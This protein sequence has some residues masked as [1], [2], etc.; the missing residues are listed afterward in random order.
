[1][2]KSFRRRARGFTLI[3]IAI[4]LF[5]VSLLLTMMMRGD[6]LIQ[7]SRVQDT[8]KIAAGLSTASRTFNLRYSHLPG[9]FPLNV[10]A[11]EIA[12]ANFSA[13]CMPG[14]AGTGDGNGS[15]SITES[16]CVPQHLAAAGMIKS[17]T[18]PIPTQYGTVK[19]ISNTA[20]QTAA[21]ANPLPA[22]IR[23]VIEFSGLPCEVAQ[24]ID[25]TIDDGNL[26][27]GNARASVA[28]CTPNGANDPVP[29]YAMPL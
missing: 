6:S 28:A 8:I 15:I 27:T 20:S 24:Q 12:V 25:R 16:L 29:F 18:T 14:V 3:E 1:M 23:N 4:A 17:A 10:A 19:V 7:A 11:P 2:S 5:I 26:A 21:G 13:N 22:N 9:D